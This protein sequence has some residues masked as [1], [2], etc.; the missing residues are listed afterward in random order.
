MRGGLSRRVAGAAAACLALACAGGTGGSRGG[1]KVADN[2]NFPS[3]EQLEKLGSGPAPSGFASLDVRPVDS[4]ELA[5]PFPDSIRVEPYSDPASPWGSLVDEAARRRVGLVV[6]TESMYCVARELGRFYLANGGQPTPSLRQFITSRCNAPVARIG[7][8]Y[9]EGEVPNELGEADLFTHWKGAVAKA[10]RDGLRGGPQTAGIWFGREGGRAV[11]MVAFGRRDLLLEPV[12]PFPAPDG[13]IELRGE[14]LEPVSSVRALVNRGR[15]G[16]RECEPVG[17]AALPAFHLRCEVDPGDDSALISLNTFAPSRL[18][19][20]E[21]LVVLAWPG[22][23]PSA[24]YRRPVYGEAWPMLDEQHFG[25]G[26]VELL[27]R[28]RRE[29][30]LEPLELDPGQSAT[31]AELA[32]HYF[33]SIYGQGEDLVA[34]VIV[35]GLLAGWT[36]DGIVQAGHFASAWSLRTRDLADLLAT[37]LEH[38]GGRETLLAD[39]V[40]RI[41]IGPMLSTEAGRESVAAVFTT[42]SLFSEKSHDAIARRVYEKLE[43]ERERR[44]VGPPERLADVAGLC[45]RVASSV[46]AGADPTDA[47]DALLEQSLDVLQRPVAGWIA[48][49]SEIESLEFP[50]EYLR[51]PSL[52]VAVAVS[53][54]RPKGEA[55]GRFVVMLVIADPESHGI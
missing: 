5:G 8:Q 43:A 23:R 21:G 53:H 50:E 6:P 12:S 52:G 51:K 49:V 54:R 3:P 29:A 38:P 14:A 39:D 31:A 10:I 2:R 18:L 27:N 9:V 26:F 15:F 20:R 40:E 17:D 35:L 44:G 32:P 28:V 24:V 36:V 19:G 55:W 11:A 42:Y 41:A 46:Q 37:A 4:W 25:E 1:G 34:D 30:G 47:L 7:F 48:E 22:G 13:G 45:Q 33:A 16:V